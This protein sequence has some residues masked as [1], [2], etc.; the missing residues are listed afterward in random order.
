MGPRADPAG[1]RLRG[2]AAREL[3]NQTRDA[4][5]LDHR[6]DAARPDR[7]AVRAVAR[8][9]PAAGLLQYVR[10]LVREQQLARGR[11]RLI[12][13]PRERDVAA[14]R[15]GS[16]AE[17]RSGLRGHVVRVYAHASEVLTEAR[18]EER[19][20]AVI[21]RRAASELRRKRKARRRRGRRGCRLAL[22]PLLGL[23]LRARRAARRARGAFPLHG[24]PRRPHDAIGDAV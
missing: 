19:T 18:L 10:E 14:E 11:G 22:H 20:R 9:T 8:A 7:E 1:E 17:R 12:L 16:R 15:E 13:A 2:I 4:S 5:A 21:E 24:R 23:A 3:R 6:R